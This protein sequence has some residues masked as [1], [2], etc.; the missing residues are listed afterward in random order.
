MWEERAGSSK[1]ESRQGVSS[2][3]LA[4]QVTRGKS[5]RR[6]PSTPREGVFANYCLILI[7]QQDLPLW[8]WIVSCWEVRETL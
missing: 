1:W 3:P 8:L 4:A 2:M 5:L 6:C 7:T